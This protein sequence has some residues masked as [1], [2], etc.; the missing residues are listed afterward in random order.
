MHA[1]RVALLLAVLAGSAHAD[2]PKHFKNGGT[3][4]TP[5]GV[6]VVLPPG[7]YI[8]EPDYNRLDVELR[9]LQEA[10]TRLAAENASLRKSASTDWLRWFAIGAVVGAAGVTG[11]VV[12]K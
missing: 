9:R 11:Y 12:W 10:E 3:V 6:T 5:K 2:P 7:Y 8:T 4:T 1:P